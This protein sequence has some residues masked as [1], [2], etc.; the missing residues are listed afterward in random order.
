MCTAFHSF[1]LFV[2]LFLS[3][4]SRDLS[5][6]RSAA[7]NRAPTVANWAAASAAAACRLGTVVRQAAA[8][9]YCE[10]S[11]RNF[12]FKYV[13]HLAAIELWKDLAVPWRFI[14][15]T[16]RL[17]KQ[18][19][20]HCCSATG[21]IFARATCAAA[22]I[23]GIWIGGEYICILYYVYRRRHIHIL[24]PYIIICVQLM[25]SKYARFRHDNHHQPAT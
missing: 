25:L 10:L 9:E 17:S 2:C 3:A 11:K 4:A 7:D 21:A 6:V 19:G 13:F 1:T 16:G 12:F 18:M 14:S 20:T 8:G 23:L 24:S 5:R 15:P 22:V